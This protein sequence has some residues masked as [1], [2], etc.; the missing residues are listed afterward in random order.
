MRLRLSEG[1][2]IKFFECYEERRKST[3]D[4]EIDN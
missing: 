4:L 2:V 1:V 3:K